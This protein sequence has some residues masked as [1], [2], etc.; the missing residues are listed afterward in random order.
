MYIF[1]NRDIILRTCANK[2]MGETSIVQT[3]IP[4]GALCDSNDVCASTSQWKRSIEELVV[5]IVKDNS[6]SERREKLVR[7]IRGCGKRS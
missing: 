3:S 6:D 5:A 2:P 1:G 4:V 7:E